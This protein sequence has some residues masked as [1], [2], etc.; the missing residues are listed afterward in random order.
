MQV[1]LCVCLGVLFLFLNGG[2]NLCFL[3]GGVFVIV[4][5]SIKEVKKM[6]LH[7]QQFR[8]V[9]LPVRGRLMLDT[10]RFLSL[11]FYAPFS[12][13]LLFSSFN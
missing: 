4:N 1:F 12:H 9:N 7:S 13:P 5:I 8:M 11:L 10:K 6:P 2:G 3:L